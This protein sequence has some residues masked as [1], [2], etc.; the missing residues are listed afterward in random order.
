[1]QYNRLRTSKEASQYDMCWYQERMAVRRCRNSRRSMRVKD[2]RL[3]IYKSRLPGRLLLT[4]R[5]DAEPSDHHFLRVC[6]PVCWIVAEILAV[7]S[8]DVGPVPT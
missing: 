1:M 7:I 3:R 2:C 5:G 4:S 6:H 8:E